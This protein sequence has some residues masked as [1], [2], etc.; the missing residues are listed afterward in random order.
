MLSPPTTSA[1]ATNSARILT[2]LRLSGAMKS[3]STLPLTFDADDNR[4]IINDFAYN[5]LGSTVSWT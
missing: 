2:L 3:S 5:R 1:P 4:K